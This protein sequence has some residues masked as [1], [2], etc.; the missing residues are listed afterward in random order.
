MTWETLVEVSVR[1]KRFYGRWMWPGSSTLSWS[2]APPA[3][4]FQLRQVNLIHFDLFDW[5]TT[6]S[7]CFRA[8]HCVRGQ[9]HGAHALLCLASTRNSRL[10]LR[11][12][13]FDALLSLETFATLTNPVWQCFL[14]KQHYVIISVCMWLTVTPAFQQTYNFRNCVSGLR[15]GDMWSLTEIRWNMATPLAYFFHGIFAE[16]ST[17]HDPQL[18]SQTV[19]DFMR[20]HRH[21][22]VSQSTMWLRA[23]MAF[24][25]LDGLLQSFL[26][27]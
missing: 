18:L 7:R 13:L 1:R 16:Y 27:W 10:P 24:P 20:F 22:G 23:D 15:V 14:S 11:K 9:F 26:V 25:P 4:W 17:G 6:I 8:M 19:L 12:R 21:S 3:F 5:G 2:S